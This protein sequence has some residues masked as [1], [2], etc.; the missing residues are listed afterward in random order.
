[1][2]RRDPE[3]RL[4]HMLQHAQEAVELSAGKTRTD[5]SNLRLLQLGLVRLVDG[6]AR[7]EGGTGEVSGRS[8]G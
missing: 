7:S 1:M 3:I 4:R 2:T 6:C 5:F 8:V